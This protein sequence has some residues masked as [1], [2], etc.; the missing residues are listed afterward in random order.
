MS[1]HVVSTTPAT[2]ATAVS[3]LSNVTV[4]FSGT[5]DPASVGTA[6]VRLSWNNRTGPDVIPATITYDETTNT[7]VIDP[8]G[9]LEY[10]KLHTVAVT[11]LR[12]AVDTAVDDVT[13]SFRTSVNPELRTTSRIG[14]SISHYTASEVDELGRLE[15]GTTFNAPGSDAQWFTADDGISSHF[16]RSEI[17]NGKYS[18]SHY[19][20]AGA[21][22]LW[23]TAD[24]VVSWRTRHELDAQGEVVFDQTEYPGPDAIWD[25]ADDAI[26]SRSETVLNGMGDIARVVT[27]SGAGADGAWRT[28]DDVVLR[29][30]GYTY[31]ASGRN[32]RWVWLDG[33]GPDG[34]WFNADDRAAGY[35][36]FQYDAANAVIR[37]DNYGAGVDRVPLTS[38]DVHAYR[39]ETSRDAN[40]LA[41][42]L[43]ETF[44]PGVDG[45]WDTGSDNEEVF[46]TT[47]SHDDDGQRVSGATYWT[48]AD[49]RWST[50]DDEIRT[51]TSFDTSW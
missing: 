35:L 50:V 27:F 22:G 4:T 39:W 1:P 16:A 44:G 23:R 9:A 3:V 14:A 30:T 47:W 36:S 21:D 13:F 45:D 33:A 41:T 17:V 28:A 34:V 20:A 40:G 43:L 2:D 42:A 25:T 15:R 5:L 31:D 29:Y 8:L 32:T 48:G 19:E 51:T 26:G 24:D 6:S 11:G 38:D 46:G 10:A 12:S 37:R 18:V 7:I 49:S